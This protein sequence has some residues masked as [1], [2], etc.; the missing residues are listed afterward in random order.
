[1]NKSFI[2]QTKQRQ[3]SKL[4]NHPPTM[5]YNPKKNYKK[6][7][8]KKKKKKKQALTQKSLKKQNRKYNTS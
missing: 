6:L 2:D 1:M 8:K 3:T 4:N 5:A 7:Q